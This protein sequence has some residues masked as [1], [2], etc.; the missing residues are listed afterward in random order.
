MDKDFEDFIALRCGRAL[1]ECEEYLQSEYD[2]ILTP[3]QLKSKAEELCY[4]QGFLDAIKIFTSGL[5][6]DV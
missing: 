5:N 6:H 3:D 2:G 1:Q 4:K